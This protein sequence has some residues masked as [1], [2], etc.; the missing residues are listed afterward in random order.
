MCYYITS[1]LPEGTNLEDLKPIFEEFNMYFFPI[2]NKKLKTQFRPGELYFRTTKDYCDCD[3][4]L[5]SNNPLQE[6]E[7][8]LKSKKI[9]SL[10]KKKW[11]N[12]QIQEW[13]MDKIKLKSHKKSHK[14]I[15]SERDQELKKWMDFISNLLKFQKLKRIG[16]IKHWYDADLEGEDFKIKETKRI[17]IDDLNSDFLLNLKEDVLYEFFMSSY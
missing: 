14:K 17:N 11:S 4:V 10:K 1:T 2:D 13:I 6:Y 5:G 12:E 7:K 3:T 15:P 8:L 9:K 16:L